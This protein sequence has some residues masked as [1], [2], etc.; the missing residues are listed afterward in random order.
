MYLKFLQKPRCLGWFKTSQALCQV[1]LFPHLLCGWPL[2]YG[3][4]CLGKN[5]LPKSLEL[6][7]FSLTHNSERHERFFF[8]CRVLF[9]PVISLQTFSPRNQ[10]AGSF[11]LKSPITYSKVKCS[12]PKIHQ[13]FA[14]LTYSGLSII[15][16]A[17]S[18]DRGQNSLRGR[19]G[20]RLY[21]PLPG[22]SVR[23]DV[24]W[25]RNQILLGMELHARP[26]FA[27]AEAPL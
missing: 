13:T 23:T 26:R 16:K 12:A 8:Q 4:F 20:I 22:Q 1:R 7:I 25:R 14:Q 5:F 3:W 19:R 10:S 21:L 6:E 27:S 24:P 15:S 11:F 18:N 9:F 17:F 2:G